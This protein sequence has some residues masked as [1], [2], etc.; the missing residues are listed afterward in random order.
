[1]NWRNKKVL[2]T[3]ADGFI[4]SHLT[5]R[6]L[7]EGA[8]VRAFVYYNSFGTRGWL[9]TFPKEKLKKLD[10][11]TGDVRDPNGVFDAMKDVDI[12]FHLAALI[13][14]PFSYH[15]PDSYI[16][17]NIKGTLNI[18]QAAR[19]LK[20]QKII[21]TS[22]SEIFGSAQYVPMDE[23]H[24][25][26]PQ[27]PY[28]ATKAAADDLA[29]SFYRSFNLPVT[30]IRP[31]NT[32]GPRQSARA[33]IPTVIT[34]IFAGQKTIRLGNLDAKRDFNYVLNLVDAFLQLAQ[35]PGTN[36]EI[37]NVG[38]GKSI[39]VADLVRA[40]EKIAGRKVTIVRESKRFRPKKSE[41]DRLQCDP[42]RI[43]KIC[44]WRQAV[45]FEDGLR[46]TC[47]WFQNNL[48][49]YKTDIYHV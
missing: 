44:K 18:L 22:T 33:I 48:K 26:R 8:R 5:E 36:G 37:F 32:F 38:S 46:E 49:L 14:I 2:V 19:K 24:P 7:S 20:T 17:T 13:G 45:S 12:V 23:G 34:Q 4:G 39:S 15:S 28:A 43:R 30:V 47:R 3:G 35:T 29:L 27:S 16:D 42:K 11:F 10:I 1:M 9:D 41:V 31:F 21:H 25:I 40:V 6:L